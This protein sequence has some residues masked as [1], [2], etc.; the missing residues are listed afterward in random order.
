MTDEQLHITPRVGRI[1]MSE[2]AIYGLILVSGMIV[3]SARGTSW[4]AFVTVTVTVIVFFAAHVFAGTLGRLAATDG[5]AGLRASLRASARQS[6]GM[7]IASVPPLII[8]LLGATR[9]IED[10]AALWAAL[11]A[12]TVLLG[13]LGWIAVA[14]W[15]THWLPR[16]LSALIT[17]A[18]GGVLILLKAVIHH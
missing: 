1:L 11:I 2:E 16:I 17:A 4:E 18:F 14:R 5:H 15:S 7:L 12:N 13:A 10:T 6:G 3:V 9:V 8:L